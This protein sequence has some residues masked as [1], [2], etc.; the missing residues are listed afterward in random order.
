MSYSSNPRCVGLTSKGWNVSPGGSRCSR[1][2]SDL[3]DEAAARLEMRC[4]VLEAGDLL[5]LRRQVHDRVGDE[6]G[7]RERGLDGR[8]GEV[9][10]RDADP[11]RT[12]LRTQSRHHRLGQIDPVH[13]VRRAA[14]AAARSVPCRC[15]ARARP[16]RGRDPPGRRRWDRRRQDRPG[17]R[18]SRRSARPHARRSGPRA[19]THSRKASDATRPILAPWRPQPTS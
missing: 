4:G 5:V 1:G 2:T 13:A 11:L 7:D 3:D 6:V 14:R 19:R 15:R 8:R 17:T 12:G 16:R 9:A 18:T 10:D